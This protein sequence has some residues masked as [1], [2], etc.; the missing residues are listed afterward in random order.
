[1]HKKERKVTMTRQCWLVNKLWAWSSEVSKDTVWKCNQLHT[2]K[3]LNSDSYKAYN[4]WLKTITICKW[5]TRFLSLLFYSKFCLSQFLSLFTSV[6]CNE[7][8]QWLV[9]CQRQMCSVKWLIE[10][11]KQNQQPGYLAPLIRNL[12]DYIHAHTPLSSGKPLTITRKDE[13][14]AW[15]IH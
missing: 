12:D 1:M 8:A 10:N 5:K 4:L 7:H 2:H 11:P 9:L 3:M 15:F 6:F 14:N 13:N